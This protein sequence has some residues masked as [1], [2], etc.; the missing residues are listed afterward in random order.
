MK[1]ITYLRPARAS[2]EEAIWQTHYY[3]VRY[4][5]AQHYDET[6]RHHWLDLIHKERALLIQPNQTLWVIEYD[7]NVRGF[8]HLND[9]KAQLSALYVHPFFQKMGLGTALLQRAEQHISHMGLSVLSLY[10]PKSAV[11]FFKLNGYDVL[12]DAFMPLNPDV[13]IPCCLM[14]KNLFSW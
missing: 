7:G 13:S 1:L 14:R 9:E 10:A 6:I 5:C 2:D 3:A 12:T 11:P 4:L 8:F